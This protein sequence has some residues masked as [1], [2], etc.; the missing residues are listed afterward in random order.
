MK[1]STRKFVEL[2]RK[3]YGPEQKAGKG[4]T[5]NF[6][7]QVSFA[8]GNSKL[9]SN[10]SYFYGIQSDFIAKQSDELSSSPLGLYAALICESEETVLIL[11][12]QI[13]AEAMKNSTSDRIN[14]VKKDTNYFLRCSGSPLI[15]VTSY[16]NSY[17]EQHK[18]EIPVE[19]S[20]DT[21]ET[22]EQQQAEIR[23][24][25]RI[26][27]MLI[28]FGRAA[29]SSIWVPSGDKS[30]EFN[31]ERLA[32]ITIPELP[33]FGFDTI[34][35]QIIS[36]IDVLW[37]E[38]NVIHKAFEIESTTSIYSGLLRMSD[39]VLSQP[40]VNID[41]HIVAP[42]RRREIV[43]KNILRPTFSKLRAKCSYISFEEITTKYTMVKELLAKQRTQIRDL[44]ESEMF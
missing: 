4:N 42:L 5:L 25:T 34:N 33:N 11:P 44:L 21:I 20:K 6:G 24:H 29:G 8:I 27:W 43:R 18:I 19:K 3:K 13:V 9:H 26:Q 16:L 10:G 28:Q 7:G 36:N 37:L 12:Q 17:P 41:L 35:R 2:M 40:N 32:D 38:G 30:K 22:P 31:G 15:E 23:D 39:L 14:I 1:E